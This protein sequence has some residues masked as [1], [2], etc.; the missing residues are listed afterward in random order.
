MSQNE[1]VYQV[2]KCSGKLPPNTKPVFAFDAK[3]NKY[4]CFYARDKQVAQEFDDYEDLPDWINGEDDPVTLKEGWYEECENTGYHDLMI[5]KRE[6][7]E[8]LEETTSL[9][10]ALDQ[11]RELREENERLKSDFNQLYDSFGH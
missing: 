2:V 7:V 5:Y 4:S 9:Q 8:W 6:I 3:G 11:V 1:K 10:T